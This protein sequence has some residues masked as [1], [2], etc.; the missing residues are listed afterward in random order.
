MTFART[1]TRS[2]PEPTPKVMENDQ[3][4]SKPASPEGQAREGLA[5]VNCSVWLPIET[6]PKDGT[7]IDIWLNGR[8]PDCYW[9][10]PNHS[11]GEMG[12]YCDSCPSYDGWVDDFMGYLTGDE[13]CYLEMPTHWMAIPAPPNDQMQT[14]PESKPK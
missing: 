6:A 13:G 8:H 10:K 12:Q 7:R 4:Q 1:K 5:A 3:S 11:C 2:N 9:G 14:T